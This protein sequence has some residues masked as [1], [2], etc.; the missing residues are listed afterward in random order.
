[1]SRCHSLDAHVHAGPVAGSSCQVQDAAGHPAQVL[2]G[3][4]DELGSAHSCKL[5]VAGLVEARL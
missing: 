2:T 4:S 1:M 5:A 3:F